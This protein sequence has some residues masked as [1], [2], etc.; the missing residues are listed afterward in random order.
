MIVILWKIKVI[1]RKMIGVF[2]MENDHDLWA[3]EGYL[4]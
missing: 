1:Y 2:L 3:N 4:W